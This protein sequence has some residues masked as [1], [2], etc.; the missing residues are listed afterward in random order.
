MRLTFRIK[1]QNNCAVIRRVNYYESSIDINSADKY[2]SP[3]PPIYKHGTNYDQHYLRRNFMSRRSLCPP[4]LWT[5]RHTPIRR[6]IR[7]KRTPQLKE[8]PKKHAIQIQFQSGYVFVF[9]SS[10]SRR[11][12]S[13]SSSSFHIFLSVGVVVA[14]LIYAICM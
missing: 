12:F 2:L 4:D 14:F 8:K 10:V 9:F 6:N 7:E 3:T 5:T 11:L 13:S 1:V